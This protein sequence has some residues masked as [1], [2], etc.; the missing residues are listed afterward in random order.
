MVHSHRYFVR[1]VVTVLRIIILIISHNENTVPIRKF[2]KLLI[3]KAEY[4]KER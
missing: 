4:G 2:S 3:D 1:N